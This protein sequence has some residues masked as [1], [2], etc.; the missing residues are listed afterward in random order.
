MEMEF[1]INDAISLSPR[2]DEM[3]YEFRINNAYLS[4][5]FF[6]LFSSV[7]V[8]DA[9]QSRYSL[10]PKRDEKEMLYY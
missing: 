4:F 9:N 1:R 5:F 3:K 6:A 2:G 8:C 10:T 7:K